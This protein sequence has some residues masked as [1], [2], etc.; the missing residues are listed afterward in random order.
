MILAVWYLLVNNYLLQ[1]NSN[2]L[3]QKENE[4]LNQIKPQSQKVGS[5]INILIIILYGAVACYVTSAAFNQN[6][7]LLYR[8]GC[9]L[10]YSVAVERRIAKP[11]W[12]D[13][14]LSVGTNI[15]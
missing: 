12:Y 2:I 7:W 13:N 3:L 8:E 6:V 10:N 5:Y 4:L 11:L 1:E 15:L 14:R 9:V